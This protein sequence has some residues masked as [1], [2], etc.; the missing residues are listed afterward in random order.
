MNT[1]SGTGCRVDRPYNGEC[2]EPGD[3]RG[4]R[5][6][7]DPTLSLRV[8]LF[9]GAVLCFR[10]LFP[11]LLARSAARSVWMDAAGSSTHSRGLLG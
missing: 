11:L 4:L 1:R 7:Q 10:V 9:V 2:A 8:P 5:R 3:R 6:I